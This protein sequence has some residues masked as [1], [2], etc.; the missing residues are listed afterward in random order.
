MRKRF[1][2]TELLNNEKGF[3][4]LTILVM[5]SL[6]LSTLPLLAY[7]IKS[8]SISS[9]YDDFSIQ[10]FFIYFRNEFIQAT[11]FEL[12]NNGVILYFPDGKIASFEKFNDLIIRRIDG[13]F[14]VYLREV[15]DISFQPLAYGLQTTVTSLQGEQYEKTIIFY[16]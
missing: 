15:K 14:E 12:N 2:Y 3:T 5:I 8:V 1:V 11:H 6:M 13:G 7:L 16:E 10:Q 9:N 4:L